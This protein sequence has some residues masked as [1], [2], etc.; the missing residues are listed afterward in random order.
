[1]REPTV[2]GWAEEQ[3]PTPFLYHKLLMAK[4]TIT[5]NSM[6]MKKLLI[7]FF[8]LAFTSV[9]YA[10]K[11]TEQQALQK[12]QQFF[13]DKGIVSAN[14]RRAKKV[15]QQS[16]A[17][18]EDFYVF[19]AENNGGFVIISGDDRTEEILGYADSGSLDMDN[20]PP[21][22]KGWL[23]GYSKQIDVIRQENYSGQTTARRAPSTPRAAIEPLIIT[24]WG[25]DGPY[26]LMCPEID[27]QRCITGCVATAMAQ[28][29]YYHKWP[30][31]TCAAIP[32]YTTGT[33]QI[34]MAA[35]PPT[36][37]KWDKMRDRYWEGETG[38]SADAVAELMRYCGQA[39]TMD[40]NI[41]E[42][43]AFEMPRHLIQYF[44]YSK[45]A[46]YITMS[47]YT[48]SQWEDILY[49]ELSEGR[50]VLY[51]G[52]SV[53]NAHEFICDGYDG[54]GYYHF[55]WGWNG[56][57]D[58]FFL[59]SILYRF[60]LYGG[61]VA[62]QAAIIGLE[63]EKGETVKPYV[64]GFNDGQLSQTNYSRSST[65]DN[66]TNV[67][68]NGGI[69][70]QYE[71]D[72]PQD[73]TLDYGLGLY[74]GD[75]L[76]SVLKQSTATLNLENKAIANE[77]S[78]S[79][80]SNL[81][82]G[83]YQIRHIYKYP[84]SET[85][86]TCYDAYLNYIVATISG[87]T[88]TLRN[89]INSD[90]QNADYIVNDVSFSGSIGNSN[91][92][93]VTVNLTNI[94]DTNQE[95]LRVVTRSEGITY[96]D[97]LVC[98]FIAPGETGNIVFPVQWGHKGNFKMFIS[99]SIECACTALEK[100][101][102]EKDISITNSLNH[103]L[104]CTDYSIKNFE[105]GLLHDYKLEI[106][107]NIE[108]VGDNTFEDF[109]WYS[110]QEGF[111]EGALL[112]D[113]QPTPSININKGESKTLNVTIPNLKSNTSYL[114]Y[115]QYNNAS[116]STLLFDFPIEIFV[117]P[118]TC[119]YEGLNYAYEPDAKT[120]TVI[121]GD[122]QQLE[123]VTIPSSISVGGQ[124]YMVTEI[125]PKSFKNSNFLSVCLPEGL[126]SIGS[127]AFQGCGIK[128]INIPSSLK[129][130]GDCAFSN[131][132]GIKEIVLPEGFVSIRNNAF[133]SCRDLEVL[134]L[135]STLK[136]VGDYV[137]IDCSNL[138]SVYSAMVE[139]II[140][141]EDAFGYTFNPSYAAL[142][143]PTGSV[144]K[145][146]TA[147]GW[148]IFTKITDK[149]LIY[150]EYNGLN[151]ECDPY[152]KTASVIAGNYQELESINIPSTIIVDGDSYAV[153]E[154]LSRT[155]EGC[156]VQSISLPSTLKRI[157]SFAFNGVTGVKEI[158]I[159]EGV[160]SVGMYAFAYCNDLMVLKIPSTLESIGNFAFGAC[161]SLCV[162]LSGMRTP[163]FIQEST[164]VSD[165][166]SSVI[167]Q[168]PT[169]SIEKYQVAS[170]WNVFTRITDKDVHKLIYQVDGADYKTVY[171]VEGDPITP[172]SSPEAKDTY[173]FFG[174]SEI[175]ETMPAHDVIV[176]GTFERHFDVGH[177]VNV[178]NF[179]MGNNA[180]PEDIALYDMNN[181]NELNI[182][183][184]IL[185]VKNILNNGSA[186]ARLAYRRAADRIDFALYTAA[187]F[188]LKVDKNASIK[189][190]RLVGSM[191]QSHQL[192]CQ[193]KDD[194][195]YVVVVYSLTNQ[196]MKPENGRIVDVEA[197]GGNVMM[198]NI[199]VATQTGEMHYYQDY[200]MPTDIHQL[201]KDG[202]SAVIYDLKGN[203]LNGVPGQRKGVYIINGKKVVV[204]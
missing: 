29:M 32:A 47:Q 19:N 201:E 53:S 59:P 14:P 34:Q 28:V 116:Q 78:L 186:T 96:D 155:F 134:R 133:S 16:D 195:T 137:I 42:S 89:A 26:N 182:G 156:N 151:Y 132:S 130:I 55:N 97:V 191:A 112:F 113:K 183:D 152:S 128:S 4:R 188:E 80:G 64:Y 196:L 121:A 27:G 108:N 84:N 146:Q 200:G 92:T 159:P 90:A 167:L 93:M 40:Y 15:E 30:Q 172:E 21:N 52:A 72:V 62:C 192:M 202:N 190:I 122:Y 163:I 9:T 107:L 54:N 20:L 69:Y 181:D 61:Y 124:S 145:Y 86:Q 11:V 193:Q 129:Y 179:I 168:V 75:Q 141:P 18:Q 37:F 10:E 46:K 36:A 44:G 56:M 50:P 142:Y 198:Q 70:I 106:T 8:T 7:L 87:T 12:A 88:M 109:I 73:V 63:P 5:K 2:P 171:V 35:L 125:G 6:M 66:F 123:S 189:D 119:V 177:V 150:N 43:G 98:G 45:N 149:E 13:K 144:E 82:D 77:M 68:L 120:A 94:G 25:Q 162:I 51:E 33:R 127:Y 174:W 139:P 95:L 81:A 154:I 65:S 22:L 114:L 17:T 153:E 48:T 204:R 71:V 126:A 76:L 38:E 136:S 180:T 74:Q 83:S 118:N 60:K 203:R 143:V 103:Q 39:V 24:K 170:G 85:W 135:P 178:V 147:T 41:D 3:T 23:E 131:S 99:S 1:M 101:K 185:I 199:T 175:P 100:V 187:Q 140:V 115:L 165:N 105:N 161:N 49:K 31:E 111:D 102:W 117:S 67:S 91:L 110:L 157:G 169:G 194:N 57:A 164:F 58:G 138:K 166:I 104:K 148:N 79:F 197:D 173:Q 160:V 158:Q 176:T 184:I